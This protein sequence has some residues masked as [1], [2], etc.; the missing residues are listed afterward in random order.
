MYP[1][2]LPGLILTTAAEL[3][4]MLLLL[5][6][7]SLLSLVSKFEPLPASD[8]RFDLGFDSRNSVEL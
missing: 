6:L 4:P 7:I 2:C 1:G 8:P 5:A 3:V